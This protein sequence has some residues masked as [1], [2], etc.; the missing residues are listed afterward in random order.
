[1]S[2]RHLVTGSYSKALLHRFRKLALHGWENVTELYSG[3]SKRPSSEGY[4]ERKRWAF[5]K[6]VWYRQTQVAALC[7]H[8]P[9]QRTPTTQGDFQFLDQGM[10]VE[11]GKG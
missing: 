5:A 6:P 11:R 7:R 10:E 9:I 2:T 3:D 4:Q 8:Y 1:M